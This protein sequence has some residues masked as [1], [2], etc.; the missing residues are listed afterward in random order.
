MTAY[1]FLCLSA[2]LGPV[3]L[4]VFMLFLFFGPP[5]LIDLGLSE[6]TAL[7]LNSCLCLAFFIQHSGM[8]RR[9]F[10]R[11]LEKYMNKA[12]HNA[13]Y[14]IISGIILLILIVF[15]QQSSQTLAAATGNFRWFLRA[16]FF[17]A[18][19]GM[20]WSLVA[21]GLNKP[22]GI[23]PILQYLRGKDFQQSEHLII[24]GPYRW[25]RHPLYL[26]NIM[27][28]WFYP[29]LTADRLL[30]N[31]LFTFWMLIG[32]LLEERDLVADFGEEYLDYKRKVPVLIPY[33]GKRG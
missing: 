23:S 18:C 6:P 31:I 12:F 33:R 20:N 21:Q 4:A 17:M 25:V 28:I 3:S 1:V 24:R 2:L 19:A 27:F 22:F 11:W 13:F 30:F 7:C 10:R 15:W 14:S 26:F 5:N 9:P 29:D 32:I 8:T 16:V